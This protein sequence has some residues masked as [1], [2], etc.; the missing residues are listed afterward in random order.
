MFARAIACSWNCECVCECFNRCMFCFVFIAQTCRKCKD[1]W[2]SENKNRTQHLMILW[3]GF[4]L[5]LALLVHVSCEYIWSYVL[6]NTHLLCIVYFEATYRYAN[7]EGKKRALNTKIKLFQD[8]SKPMIKVVLPLQIIPDCRL[9]P[10][11]TN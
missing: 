4:R 2:H 6:L 3:Q 11:L 10:T 5:L 9:C 8:I 1:L 7:M